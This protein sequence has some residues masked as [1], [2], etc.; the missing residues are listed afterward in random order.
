VQ[1]T[2]EARGKTWEVASGLIGDKVFYCKIV[3]L[4]PPAG[5]DIPIIS[6]IKFRYSASKKAE[7]DELLEHMVRTIKYP[8][9][10][11]G[12]F[13]E[14]NGEPFSCGDEPDVGLA[15]ARA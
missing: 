14:E 3:E 9:P 4:C 12:V 10:R 5:C 15:D 8:R 7:Y 1:V 11:G 13:R 2:Y 6:S